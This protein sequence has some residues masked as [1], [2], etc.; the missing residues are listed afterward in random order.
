LNLIVLIVFHQFLLPNRKVVPAPMYT[1]GLYNNNN[2]PT[3]YISKE[4]Y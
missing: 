1:I 2:N 3:T 4:N